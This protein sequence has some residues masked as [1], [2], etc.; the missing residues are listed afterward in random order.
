MRVSGWTTKARRQ[1]FRVDYLV[2]PAP[3]TG[4]LIQGKADAG[5][6]MEG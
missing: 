2:L 5:R 1:I 6:L 3:R 4:Y